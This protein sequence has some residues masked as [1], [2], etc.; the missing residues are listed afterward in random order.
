MIKV[1]GGSYNYLFCV[2]DVGE[3]DYIV[4]RLEELEQMCGRLK[5]IPQAEKA[6]SQSQLILEK[7]KEYLL[8]R[9]SIESLILAKT[10]EINKVWQAIEYYDSGDWGIEKV[11]SVLNSF[12]HKSDCC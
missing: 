7:L 12:N 4:E 1:S 11:E 3:L 6:Y 8:S 5:E 9:D 10:E 2:N